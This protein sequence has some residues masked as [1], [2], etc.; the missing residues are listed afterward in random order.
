MYERMGRATGAQGVGLKWSVDSV[1]KLCEI[2]LRYMFNMEHDEGAGG[3]CLVWKTHNK[4]YSIRVSTQKGYSDR[5][6]E[7]SVQ[8]RESETRACVSMNSPTAFAKEGRKR[9]IYAFIQPGFVWSYCCLQT[10]VYNLLLLNK[11]TSLSSSVYIYAY[12]HTHTENQLPCLNKPAQK[13]LG[14]KKEVHQ[15]VFRFRFFF[16]LHT[17]FCSS[18]SSC[19]DPEDLFWGTWPAFKKQ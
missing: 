14:E 15:T 7:R 10:G 9:R 6:R 2:L 8:E 12:T 1:R 5:E 13:P 18:S 11:S 16:L 19:S 3:C 4:M 17:R